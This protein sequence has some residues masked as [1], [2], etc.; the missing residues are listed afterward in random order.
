MES[1]VLPSFTDIY[2]F[3]EVA[4]SH[5]ISRAAEKLGITQ[6]SL[7]AAMQ[8]LEDRLGIQL[9]VRERRGMWL[10]RAGRDL[11]DGGDALV[12]R[13]Q[14]L[15][16]TISKREQKPGG[17]YVLGC[18]PS[19]AMYTLA[20][21]LPRLLQT[22]P[23][24]EIKLVHDLSRKITEGVISFG[25]DLG[26]VVNPVQ[27]PDLVIR[28]LCQDV[29]TFW[30]ARQPSSVQSLDADNCVLICDPELAQ[31]QS[32]LQKLR[33]KKKRLYQR[34]MLSSSLEVIADLSTA[35]AGIGILPSRVAKLRKLRL[36]DKSLPTYKDRIC[37][38]YRVDY[39]RNQGSKT[40]IN[41]IKKSQF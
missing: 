36:L 5:S 9:F 40:I 17:Q 2:Y 41:A 28:E 25:I 1:R 31:V 21:F 23:E 6:P 30:C 34:T 12:T 8:R 33:K 20:K 22:Y 24:L 29:V 39:Q 27:H 35:G 16:A 11:L 18:H 14:Q 4:R 26:I 32:L 10:T 37:L 15:K 3:L 19:V 38:V 7:S 13:W